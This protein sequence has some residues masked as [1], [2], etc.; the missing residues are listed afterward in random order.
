MAVRRIVEAEGFVVNTDK[1]LFL[2]RARRQ[3]VT[4]AVVNQTLGLSQKE[5]RRLR[6]MLQHQ[7]QGKPLH[8]AHKQPVTSDHL[9]GMFA[10]LKILNPEQRERLDGATSPETPRSKPPR[11]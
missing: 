4:G 7:K 8:D 1:T 10:N 11:G 9:Q 6:A 3:T 5:R 2:S